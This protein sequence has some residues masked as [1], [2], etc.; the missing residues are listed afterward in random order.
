MPLDLPPRRPPITAALRELAP[1]PTVV[2]MIRT[3]RPFYGAR[4][5]DL[6]AVAAGWRRGHR[7]AG[8]AEVAALADRLWHAGIREEQ[9]VACFLLAGDR[10]ALA[11]TDPERVRAWCALLDNWETTDQL[12]MNVLGPLVAV[13]PAGRFGLLEAMAADPHPW[14]RRLA[15]VA[16]TRLAR[17]ATPPA[18]GPGSPGW[19]GPGRRPRGRPAQG[20]LWV[21]RSWLGRARPRWRLRRRQRRRLPAV[22][23][24][25]TR[26]KLPPGTSGERRPRRRRRGPPGRPGR[27]VAISLDFDGTIAPI[28]DDPAA[29]R[30]LP[31]VVDLLG[32][33]ADRYAAVALVSGRPATYLASHAA[34]PGVRY[35]GM[36][37]LEEI[38]DGRVEVD[39]R[40]E[41]ARP[42]VAA[43]ARDLAADPAVQA[44]GAHLEDKRYA[45]AV[46][47]P[48]GRRPGRWAGP[49]GEAAHPIAARHHLEVVPGPLVWELRPQVHSDKGDA[50]RRVV[51]SSGA[52][53]LLVAGRRPRR[54]A[55]LRRR[56][57]ARRRPA[58]GGPLGRGPGRAAGRGRP[59]R[60]R[61]RGGQGPARAPARLTAQGWDAGHRG[62]SR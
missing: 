55:R 27:P 33:L 18:G 16:C 39:P 15:L 26:T 11:A 41:S 2:P 62:A 1:E 59:G 47:H 20:E 6:R 45:V 30:P 43:A 13:D 29:A 60:G 56:R 46:P 51:A 10:A 7:Q 22:A 17:A 23:V 31:G 3:S 54:P 57:R 38:V 37:G 36:Y 32:P 50:V 53:P 24:R 5:G 44:S 61:P 58:G 40:L 34:A 25:E 42:A 21:L 12:G 48:P 52:R 8:P 28:V 35:L 9:L 4:V 14:T 49:I 19:S